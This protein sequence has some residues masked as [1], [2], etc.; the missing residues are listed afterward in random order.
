VHRDLKP[1]NIT[2]TRWPRQGAR[3]RPGPDQATEPELGR[4]GTRDRQGTILGTAAYEPGT[5][6]R[7]GDGPA[8]RHPSLRR[9]AVRDADRPTR[10]PGRQRCHTLAAVIHTSRALGRLPPSTPGMSVRRRSLPPEGRAIVR[11]TWRTSAWRSTAPSAART[12][13]TAAVAGVSALAHDCRARRRAAGR[14]GG[15]GVQGTVWRI[16]QRCISA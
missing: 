6:A 4:G 12:M 13:A 10:V 14:R 16:R 7:Q 15:L 2:I 8:H 9:R 11:A 3:L 5:G 1:A